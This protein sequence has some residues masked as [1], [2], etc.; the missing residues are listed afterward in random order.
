[1]RPVSNRACYLC[2]LGRGCNRR[3]RMLSSSGNIN[4]SLTSDLKESLSASQAWLSFGLM[5]SDQMN[6]V[7]FFFVC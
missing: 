5:L 3:H 1:M 6:S 2:R 7:P 4:L